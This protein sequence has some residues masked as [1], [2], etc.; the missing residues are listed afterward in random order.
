MANEVAPEGS[1]W[2]DTVTGLVSPDLLGEDSEHAAWGVKH[3]AR[4]VL[5]RSDTLVFGGAGQV[6]DGAFFDASEIERA[7]LTETD[8]LEASAL[9]IVR[10]GRAALSVVAARKAVGLFAKAEDVELAS[11]A[12]SKIFVAK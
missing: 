5:M 2:V 9:K 1:V 11:T 7:R 12:L 6:T 3:A 8:H 4:A 10:A